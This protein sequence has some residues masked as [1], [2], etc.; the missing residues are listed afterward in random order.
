MGEFSRGI[1]ERLQDGDGIMTPF[2]VTQ[3]VLTQEIVM[4]LTDIKHNVDLPADT[5]KRPTADEPEKKKAD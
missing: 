2:T 5:F 4:K 1:P 3:K